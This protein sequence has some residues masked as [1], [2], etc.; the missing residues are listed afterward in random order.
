M[1]QQLEILREAQKARQKAWDPENKINLSFRGNELAGETGELCNFIKKFERRRLGI[2]GG[3]VDLEAI[4]EE[5]ADVV[6][7]A[8]LIAM[9][10]GVDLWEAV[11]K[12][13]NSTSAKKGLEVMIP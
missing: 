4:K 12:K 7:C 8:D 10:L 9:D 13:F 2:A 3:L 1:K 5:I 11:R 6:I